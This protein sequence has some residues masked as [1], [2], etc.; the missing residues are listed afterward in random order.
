M[1]RFAARARGPAPWECKNSK[2]FHGV[3]LFHAGSCQTGLF[4]C[5]RLRDARGIELFPPTGTKTALQAVRGMR[6]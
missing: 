5:I 6:G 4:A 1:F 2:L 3:E